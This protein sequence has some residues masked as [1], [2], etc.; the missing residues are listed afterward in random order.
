MINIESVVG[1]RKSQSC[2]G[3]GRVPAGVEI[4]WGPWYLL[5]D[6]PRYLWCGLW[7]GKPSYKLWD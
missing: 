4:E 5:V 6:H 7:D 3:Y 1:L 2:P